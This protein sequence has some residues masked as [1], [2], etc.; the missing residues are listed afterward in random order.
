MQSSEV[1]FSF[2]RR[3]GAEGQ[4]VLGSKVLGGGGKGKNG[5]NWIQRVSKPV[6][7]KQNLLNQV[8]S[9]QA[10]PA[11]Q[12]R[13]ALRSFGRVCAKGS[14][15]AGLMASTVPIHNYIFFVISDCLFWGDKLSSISWILSR[16]QRKRRPTN[17][18]LR[19]ALTKM[20]E[21]W[22]SLEHWHVLWCCRHQC[23]SPVY[24]ELPARERLL[25]ICIALICDMP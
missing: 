21:T 3:T 25:P 22:S 7:P 17:C 11:G 20:M 10:V 12:I 16:G 2:L 8:F 14:V 6:E 13:E 15:P 18:E 5:R 19:L 23:Y 4:E 9:N 24:L 1:D